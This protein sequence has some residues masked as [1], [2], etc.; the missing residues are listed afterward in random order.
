MCRYDA[1]LFDADETLFNYEKAAKC[2]LLSTLSAYQIDF[3]RNVCERYQHWN[4]LV[5]RCFERGEIQ[6]S[7]LQTER[8]RKL[9]EELSIH[10]DPAGFNESYL[11]AL[12]ERGDEL[13][14]AV[15][16]CQALFPYCPLYIVTNGFTF[17]QERRLARSLLRP[18]IKKMYISEQLG[19]QKPRK[20]YFDAVLTDISLTDRSRVILLG[21]SL[22][23]DMQGGINAGIPTCWYN[24]FGQEATLPIDYEIHSLEE[25][26]PLVVTK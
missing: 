21:D 22:T 3:P 24:P 14:G 4:N 1:I 18:Y 19:F 11:L 6:K 15:E 13:P 17:T 9:F 20:E 25:F 10:A 12:A 7:E 5:W 26:F 8:F 2:A 23:S 16:L